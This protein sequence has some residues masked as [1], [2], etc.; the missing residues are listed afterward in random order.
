MTQLDQADATWEHLHPAFRGALRSVFQEVQK[1]LG[2]T[3]RLAEGYRAPER[4]LYLFASGRTR[5]GA[6][7]TWMRYPYW[8][9]S[10]LAADCY[11]RE[12][13]A[14]KSHRS[15]EVFREVYLV[16]GLS[17]PA[18]AK[19]DYGHVQLN[20]EQVRVAA[21][22]WTERGFPALPARGEVVAP[23]PAPTRPVELMVNGVLYPEAPVFLD[24]DDHCWVAARP[25]CNALG[26]ALV[27]IAG[28]KVWI[29][30]DP[31][32]TGELPPEQLAAAADVVTTLQLRQLPG[33]RDPVGYVQA[34]ALENLCSVVWNG[35]TK[36]I[37]FFT[38]A[39]R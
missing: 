23:V 28:G 19:G 3:W 11:P 21:V 17:N 39:G 30:A 38:A 37:K 29:E 10:G 15:Y 5:P 14:F 26:F 33:Q 24:D 16:H 2:V 22:A 1:R 25:L 34:S 27:K 20:D 18:W 6:V 8:H 4:Q 32:G 13:T 35:A 36:K 31:E 7:V 9:G 12:A